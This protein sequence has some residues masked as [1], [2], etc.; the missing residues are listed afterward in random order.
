MIGLGLWLM[1]A[2]GEPADPAAL[3]AAMR[4]FWEADSEA[5]Q[6]RAIAETLAVNADFDAIWRRLE[7]GRPYSA[8]VKTGRRELA[9][10]NRD[11]QRH[12]YS[13]VIPKSYRPDRAYPARFHL[14]G[15]VSGAWRPPN[16]RWPNHPRFPAPIPVTGEDWIT[17]IPSSW[18]ES[19]WWQDSQ[20]ENLEGVLADLKREYNVDENRVSLIGLSDGATGAY[21]QAFRNTTPWASF[22]PFIGH[23]AVLANLRLGV[24][25][26]MFPPNLANK[27]LMIV[28]GVHDRLYPSHTVRPY[29]DLF[30]RAG[31]DLV[32]REAPRSGHDV[33]WWPA[34]NDTV[35]GFI[36][37]RVRQPYPE[38][39]VWQ[40]ERVDRYNRAH[41]LIIDALGT[42]ANDTAFEPLNEVVPP[43]PRPVLG[44]SLNAGSLRVQGVTPNSVADKAG[45]RRG[46]LITALD[47]EAIDTPL[48]LTERLNRADLTRPVKLEAMRRKKRRELTLSF[49]EPPPDRGPV[50]AFPRR[51]PSGRALAVKTGNQVV[52]ETHGVT[53]L[54]LLLSPAVFDFEQPVQ[55][56]WHGRTAF[57]GQVAKSA[58]TLLKWAARDQDRTMLFAAELTLD[59]PR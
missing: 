45:L 53:R 17:V 25:G 54:T 11:G 18:G 58:A 32:F 50:R 30:Q 24:S 41:W 33:R 6:T 49:P 38:W 52:L 12:R 4:R 47:G 35:E 10:N 9:R 29:I 7:T 15:G 22:L 46:D 19:L 13:I 14:H 5:A 59:A 56:V 31:V 51:R 16:Q 44:V 23:P 42:T 8:D 34:A 36:A 27:P 55:V 48:A 57:E 39:I 26:E 21:F 2:W 40:T 1:T 43:R 20:A 3:E 28:N 37:A